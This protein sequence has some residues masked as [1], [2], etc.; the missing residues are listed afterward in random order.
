MECKTDMSVHIY[1]WVSDFIEHLDTKTPWIINKV[2]DL[3][4]IQ[5]I[6]K[7]YPEKK[8][9]IRPDPA[10]FQRSPS[11]FIGQIT[12]KFNGV[13]VQVN[14]TQMT[15][16][17]ISKEFNK[18]EYRDSLEKRLNSLVDLK[19]KH[20][21]SDLEY[22]RM[23]TGIKASKSGNS[24]AEAF[25]DIRLMFFGFVE[26]SKFLCARKHLRNIMKKN[27]ER[28]INIQKILN[29]SD[30]TDIS[31]VEWQRQVNNVYGIEISQDLLEM[32]NDWANLN[33]KPFRVRSISAIHS[34]ESVSPQPIKDV[35]EYNFV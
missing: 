29:S 32:V 6:L 1:Q 9:H 33:D 13:S 31:L 25:R 16:Q 27:S 30:F 19:Q 21:W 14:Y 22:A 23:I 12:S 24:S 4:N 28:S 10:S 8:C 7:L 5:I 11:I 35:E 17:E 15:S 3:R 2:K 26:K 34:T 18:N 20:K